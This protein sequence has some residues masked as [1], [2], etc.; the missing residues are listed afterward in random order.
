MC[1]ATKYLLRWIGLLS[2]ITSVIG[3]FSCASHNRSANEI[4]FWAMGAEGENVQKLIPE[5]ERKNPGITV[6]VQSIPWTAAH[7]KLL[8]AY[9]GNSTPDV[10]QLG[11]TWIPE[12]TLLDALENLDPRIR[13]S[14]AIKPGNYFPGIWQTNIIDGSVFGVPWYVDTRVLFYRTDILANAGYSHAP[15]TWD[16]L[17]DA[18]K[19]IKL[20]ANGEEKYAILLPT[21]EWAPFVVTGLQAGST[22]LKD[23]N[24]YGDFSGVEFKTAFEFLKKFYD[25]KLAP[26]GITRVTNLYQGISEGFFAMYITGP[27][28]IGEFRKRLPPELQDKWMTAPL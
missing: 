10:A 22:L 7:E 14:S 23:G 26:V 2:L 3:G 12:F 18:S 1:K 6:R 8:T 27:W 4:V 17:Y 25:E 20:A 9:A 21:N 15:R 11:N 13:S 28:N 19:K 16:E 24:R 5:F